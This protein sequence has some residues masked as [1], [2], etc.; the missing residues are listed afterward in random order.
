[1][2]ATLLKARKVLPEEWA[3]FTLLVDDVLSAEEC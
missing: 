3:P 2:K 1:V